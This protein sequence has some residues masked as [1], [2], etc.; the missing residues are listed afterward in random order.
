MK[1]SIIYLLVYVFI[2]IPIHSIQSQEESQITVDRM[3]LT[4]DFRGERFGQYNWYDDHSFTTLNL[5]EGGIDL[6]DCNNLQKEPLIKAAELTPN[7]S[8]KPLR[9]SAYQWSHDFTKMLIFTNTKRVWR[10]NT[11][12]DYWV[13][14]RSNKKLHQVGKD[15]PESSLMFTKFSPDATSVSYVS[16][17]NIYMEDLETG[18][19]TQFTKDGAERLING[20]FDWAYEEEFGCR[21][22]FR[23]SPNG[24][25]IAF[26]QVDASNIRDFLMINTWDSTYSFTVPVQ[27]PK[28]GETPAACKVGII[29][30]ETG[31]KKWLN[32]PGD[33]RQ[34][35]LPRILWHPSSDFL[36][37]QQINRKQNHLKIWKCNINTG[38]AKMV[39]EEEETTWIDMTSHADWMFLENGE[40][41]TLQS[42]K[43]GWRKF[44]KIQKDGNHEIDITPGDFDVA[45]VVS[46]SPEKDQIFFIASPDNPTQRFLYKAKISGKGKSKRVTPADAIGS[47]NYS[48]APGAEIAVHTFSD[49]NTPNQIHLVNL[50][51][52]SVEKVFVENKKLR[53]TLSELDIKPVEFFKVTT[54]EGVEM[55]GYKVLPPDFDES[56]KYPVIFYV[57]GEPAGQTARDAWGGNNL[58]HQMLAQ[59]GYIVITMDNR[60]TPSLKGR[61]WRKSI[62]RK[63]GRLNPS[64]QAMAAKEVLKW[65]YIDS[66]RVGAWGWSGGGSMTLNLLFQYPEIYKT[67]ISVAPV[68]YQLYYDNIY[69]ERYMGLPQENMDDFVKGSPVTYAKNL[70]GKLM[71]I[72]GTA[73]DNVHYQNAEVLINELIKHN[74]MFHVMPYP[75]R[76]HGI[77]EMENTSRHLRTLMNSFFNEYLEPGPSDPNRP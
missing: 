26:W 36:Y 14:D 17:H 15:F 40:Y 29:D 10:Y 53:K 44:Y 62:Y 63:I 72:H 23:W 73:D 9:I 11:K 74:K 2:W 1:K 51:K 54:A 75:G 69:Q 3:Y 24:N 25:N 30:I 37:V 55:D 18:K 19:V 60:G 46:I 66:E 28:V 58:Y 16:E 67:G 50:N 31:N 20:T 68:S 22:G 13:Y 47:H 57:Y 76:S 34:N 5:K 56:K 27:Y 7:G 35:Y 6:F 21:D 42:E 43:S 8:D 59:Q 65:K 49:I 52:H 70:K 33:N 64:D 38:E 4:S 48:I 45:N 39:Y 61:G 71:L 12:G 41:F 77:Y 32:I